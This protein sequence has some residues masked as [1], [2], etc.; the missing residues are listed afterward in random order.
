MFFEYILYKINCN[1]MQY[2]VNTYNTVNYAGNTTV[3]AANYIYECAE[4][5]CTARFKKQCCNS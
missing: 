3:G 1:N 2:F 4:G 5:T